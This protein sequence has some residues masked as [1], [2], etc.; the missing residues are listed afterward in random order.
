MQTKTFPRLGDS[1]AKAIVKIIGTENVSDAEALRI[2]QVIDMAFERPSI[3][4][5][6][7]DKA[8]AISVKLLDKLIQSNLEA[9]TISKLQ[10]V[11]Q[12]ILSAT[13]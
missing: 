5:N 2:A 9:S 7:S 11:E 13:E 1:A 10:D 6:E 12:Q 4:K 8:P 3:I